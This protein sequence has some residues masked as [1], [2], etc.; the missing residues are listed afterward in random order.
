MTG[1]VR[2]LIEGNEFHDPLDADA[3]ATGCKL[4]CT[5]VTIRGN[6]IHDMGA[7]Q[8]SH[9]FSLG[10]SG[11]PYPG[12]ALAYRVRVESNRI[13]NVQG[14]L[15]QLV[16]CEDCVVE[17]NVAWNIGAG[18]LI[19]DLDDDSRNSC[20]VAGG[21]LPTR[22]AVIRGNRLRELHG[23]GVT[24]NVFA[25]VDASQATGLDMGDNV[26]CSPSADD[27]RFHWD[28]TSLTFAAWTA[29]SMTDSSSMI[30]AHAD[31]VCVW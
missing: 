25:A 1:P 9:V 29:A 24:P 3:G 8:R 12:D 16:S 27:A 17:D 11:A 21:C 10:G 31:A 30:A 6:L 5:D 15:A 2:V 14:L 23:A 22:N 26:Y 20:S 7:D 13:W 28:G 4:G 18:V 19:A